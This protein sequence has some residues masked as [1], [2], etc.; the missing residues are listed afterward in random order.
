MEK[1]RLL[2][3]ACLAACSCS[4]RASSP[5]SIA[6]PPS[7]PA[8]RAEWQ[9]QG[10]AAY[11]KQDWRGC[12]TLLEQAGDAYDA[13]CC[14]ARA[15]APDRALAQ[16]ALAID[17]GFDQLA[18]LK[19]DT[20]L[21]SL[22]A[23]PR[24]A[25]T[26]AGLEQKIAAHRATLNPELT[27]IFEADQADRATFPTI[28]WS[29]V[30]PRDKAREKRVREV[31]AAGGAGVADDYYHAAM[32]YQHGDGPEAIAR[33][34]ELAL[35]AVEID[36]H[37]RSARWLAAASEDRLL[38]RQGKLQ[39]WGTQFG[40]KDGKWVVEDVDPAITDAQR[41]E[42]EVPPL[43]EAHARAAQMNDESP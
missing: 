42:W 2:A 28:D 29:V 7:T 14:H 19:A 1:L 30:G 8:Q 33:A 41:A 27:Q 9:A 36:P 16:L 3:L 13:A 17:G 4:G 37:H 20:D 39:K 35:K 11:E 18:H 31:L 38:V 22:H 6:P 5:S 10:L 26:V 15:G 40:K 34:H 21:E 32:V 12:A 24:W 43:A 23:D 25:A